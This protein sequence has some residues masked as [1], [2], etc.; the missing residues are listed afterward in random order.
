[1]TGDIITSLSQIE[2]LFV[3]SR[4]STFVYKNSAV[5]IQ[6]V[7]E[8]LGVRYVL[9]GSVQKA[10]NRLRI[11]AQLI[12]AITGHHLWSERFDRDESDIFLVQDEISNHIAL[13]LEVE[14]IEGEQM[15]VWLDHS[16]NPDAWRELSEGLDLFYRLNRGANARSR[17]AFNRAIEI[18]NEYALA[19][20][21]VGWT[22]WMDA[23]QNWEDRASSFQRAKSFAEKALALDDGLPIV[24]SL[25]GTLFL[26]DGENEK[27]LASAQKAVA[28]NPNHSTATALLGMIQNHVGLTEKAIPTLKHA[29]RL[30]PYHPDWFK[31]E[32]GHAY[33]NSGQNDKAVVTW[34]EFLAR[35]PDPAMAAI[36]NV[37]IAASLNELGRKEEARNALT[38]AVE[39]NPGIS[40]SELTKQQSHNSSQFIVGN[41]RKLGLPE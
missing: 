20:G 23:D 9:E 15:K 30:S 1:M 12:D 38:R 41:L 26:F 14:L 36:A 11:S 3:I 5:K 29:M 16:R 10:G 7:A 22:H 18:D 24:H 39:F 21:M 2:R 8:Q 19:Y 33:E 4:N 17:Q 32:L 34:K 37:H 28:L 35:S 27:A 40:I 6:E 25:V 31:M 13:A